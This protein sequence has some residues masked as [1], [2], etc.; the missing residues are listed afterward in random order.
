MEGLWLGENEKSEITDMDM[1][2]ICIDKSVMPTRI[3]RDPDPS[4]AIVDFTSTRTGERWDFSEPAGRRRAEKMLEI[5]S[6]GLIVCSTRHVNEDRNA[7][8]LSQ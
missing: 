6:P 2:W 5:S 1:D 4:N 3:H 8:S 7:E